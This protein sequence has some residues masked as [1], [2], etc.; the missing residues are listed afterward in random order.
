LPTEP[1]SVAAPERLWPVAELEPDRV[2]DALRRLLNEAGPGA[3]PRTADDVLASHRCADRLAAAGLTE[4]DGTPRFRVNALAGRIFV[5]DLPEATRAG[6]AFPYADEAERLLA[7]LERSGVSTA[8]AHLVDVG[9][10]CGHVTLSV[11]A[12][13]R[14]AVEVN[15]RAR[16]L[17]A[18]NARLNALEAEVVSGPAQSQL[19]GLDPIVSP[20]GET[21]VVAILPHAPAPDS[22]MLAGFAN[23][24]RTGAAVIEAVLEELAAVA[25]RAVRVVML[26]YSLRSS[27]TEATLVPRAARRLMPDRNVE[28][29]L[30]A[31]A[32]MWRI[33]GVMSERSPMALV[34]ALARKAQCRFYCD[35]DQRESTAAAYSELATELAADGWDQ[36][37]YGALDVR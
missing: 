23:G 37:C 32:P 35:A 26:C 31:G 13:R 7:Y 33:D 16:E 8:G 17:L 28:W 3:L 27:E 24:G 34:P 2:G 18:L 12:A 11:A 21:V 15:P 19:A 29:T 5:T 30:L 6:G 20:A 14:T 9:A 1:A 10:G 4:A 25:A 22:S 36:L